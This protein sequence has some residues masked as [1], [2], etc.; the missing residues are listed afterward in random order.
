MK[1][2]VLLSAFVATMTS[3]AALATPPVSS[4][5]VTVINERVDGN[6]TARGEEFTHGFC[7]FELTYLHQCDGGTHRTLV[8]IPVIVD[9]AGKPMVRPWGYFEFDGSNWFPGREWKDL[10]HWKPNNVW[11][12]ATGFWNLNLWMGIKPDRLE[13][14]YG[15]CYWRT[16]KDHRPPSC[17]Y[18]A[19][20]PWTDNYFNCKKRPAGVRTQEMRCRYSC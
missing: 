20:G 2:S 15:Q 4:A 5:D 19:L 7:S 1:F 12:M 10:T 17:G 18:C 16:D 6:L 11:H 14:N 13:F 8:K 9:G 3:V